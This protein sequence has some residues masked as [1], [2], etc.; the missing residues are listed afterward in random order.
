MKIFFIVVGLLFAVELPAQTLSPWKWQLSLK[1]DKTIS[2]LVQPA[3]LYVDSSRKRYYVVDTGNN[4]LVSFDFEGKFLSAFNA[5]G[6]LKS[7]AGFVRGEGK[8][9]WVLENGRNSLTRIDLQAK[10]T[11]PYQL[12]NKGSEVYPDRL[13]YKN[14][15]FYVLDK[16]SGAVLAFDNTMQV[17]KSYVCPDCS[18][19]FVDFKIHGN[20]LWAL[21]QSGTAVYSFPEKGKKNNKIVLESTQLSFPASFAVDQSGM[22]YVLDRH[23]GA[24]FVFDAK[25][26]FKYRFL[27]QGHVREKL[28]Y[29]TEIKFDSLERLC[30]VDEGN[31]RVEIFHR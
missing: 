30:I 14:D 21:D 15:F 23:E 26:K 16:A 17:R 4:R 28:Y 27:E 7:P 11:T 13:E 24:V 2:A 8:D 31:G 29:P 20:T 18:N 19:G 22:I 9:L 12:K 6:A 1:G 5:E 3:G 10:K 25:G